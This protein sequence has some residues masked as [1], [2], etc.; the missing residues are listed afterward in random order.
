MITIGMQQVQSIDEHQSGGNCVVTLV[1]LWDDSI[2]GI[3][4]DCVVHYPSLYD[5]LDDDGSVV[6][7]AIDFIRSRA[8]AARAARVGG[9]NI[10]PTFGAAVDRSPN[11]ALWMANIRS[12]ALSWS[13]MNQF[14]GCPIDAECGVAM[15]D[16]LSAA[17]HLI[18]TMT[19]GPQ[20]SIDAVINAS[21]DQMF[22]V[23]FG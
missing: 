23:L 4:D 21:V 13:T 20:K 3:S 1:K 12:R 8:D 18:R 9:D 6:R 17:D 19:G 15:G 2:L 11:G 10:G 5:Y 14:L 16:I 22:I 7:P